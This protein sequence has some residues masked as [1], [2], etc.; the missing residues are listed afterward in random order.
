LAL[1]SEVPGVEPFTMELAFEIVHIV[2][3]VVPTALKFAY[4][5]LQIV[6]QSHI[7]LLALSESRTLRFFVFPEALQIAFLVL[8]SIPL[9]L[10]GVSISLGRVFRDCA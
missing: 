4:L 5:P 6:D 9:V 8:E 10:N 1:I 3:K 2:L 7:L